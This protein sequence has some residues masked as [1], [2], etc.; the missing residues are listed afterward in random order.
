MLRITEPARHPAPWRRSAGL[1]E[2]FARRAA[3]EPPRHSAGDPALERLEHVLEADVEVRAAL[4]VNGND[5][6]PAPPQVAAE[7]AAAR[8]DLE[9]HA[10][11]RAACAAQSLAKARSKQAAPCSCA[12]F[13]RQR[14]DSEGLWVCSTRR[15]FFS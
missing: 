14:C 10:P 9:E 1:R 15:P 6:V 4:D 12:R 5:R 13:A 8:E 11:V 3:P 2:S 7:V